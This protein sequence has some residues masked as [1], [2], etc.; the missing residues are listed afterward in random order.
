M[1]GVKIINQYSI[2]QP[3][4]Q[5]KIGGKVPYEFFSCCWVPTVTVVA[6]SL[7]L[8]PTGTV[9]L[10]DFAGEL[11]RGCPISVAIRSSGVDSD[12]FYQRI[13]SR[14]V[15]SFCVHLPKSKS[16][17]LTFKPRVCPLTGGVTAT[18]ALSFCFP[19]YDWPLTTHRT[20]LRRSL[21]NRRRRHRRQRGCP[22]C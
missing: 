15:F 10:C 6:T 7:W 20:C 13:H 18:A 14:A 11:W 3:W 9:G 12:G 17:V 16:A 19:L 21:R 4:P 5:K 1:C 2:T 8:D 22:P